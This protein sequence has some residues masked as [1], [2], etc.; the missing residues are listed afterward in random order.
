MEAIKDT[1]HLLVVAVLCGLQHGFGIEGIKI[2][3][4]VRSSQ[5]LPFLEK[6][7]LFFTILVNYKGREDPTTLGKSY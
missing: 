5:P 1:L 4:R 3:H 2:G 7:L 6:I